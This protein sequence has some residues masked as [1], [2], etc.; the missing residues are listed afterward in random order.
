MSAR[1]GI[2]VIGRNEGERL[3]TC[4]DG[5]TRAGLPLVYVDSGSTDGSVALAREKNVQVLE[6]DRPYSAARARN[7]GIAGLLELVPGLAYV[8]FVD[9]DCELMPG[10]LE[11][12][13]C[14]LDRHG[15][16][17]AVCGR[18]RE[19]HP[20]RS[21]Y[22]LLC[23]IEW[24]APA[25]RARSC[26]GVA[27]M[28]VQAFQA[29][30]G[31]RAELIAGEEPDLCLRLRRAGWTIWRLDKEMALH[32]ASMT[33]FRQW[34]TRSKRAGYAFAQG[35]SLHGARPERFA[36]RE[37]F[38]AWFWGLAVPLV[39]VVCTAA[40]GPLGLL[41]LAAYPI[42]VIRL[43]RAGRR[44]VRENWWRALFLVLG[45]FPEMLGQVEFLKRRRGN[46]ELR[47]IEY[48]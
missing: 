22:N 1:T 24:D 45:K 29:V 23:D 6:L 28:R 44:A 26:G 47:V 30:G 18:L 39:A 12:A 15:D 40:A 5:V 8:Q 35:A 42:Q 38:S 33:S 10:W 13:G 4:L 11:E 31:F 34:W 21:I 9:G 19:R 43:A 2:V 3:R 16:V 41:V 14:H 20:E 7:A 25:G 32:D 17:A 48:K 37:S 27:M 36:V 46:A